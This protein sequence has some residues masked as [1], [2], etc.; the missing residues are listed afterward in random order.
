MTALVGWVWSLWC[1]I[2]VWIGM[3]DKGHYINVLQF[4]P[5]ELLGWRLTLLASPSTVALSLLS[6]PPDVN[7]L[8]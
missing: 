6:I 7:S 4:L 5:I 2:I 1:C 3:V 8:F